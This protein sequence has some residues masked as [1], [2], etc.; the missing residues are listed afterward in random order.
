MPSFLKQIKFA[1][2]NKQALRQLFVNFPDFFP[3]QFENPAET[4]VNTYIALNTFNANERGKSKK[5]LLKQ[6]NLPM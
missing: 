6:K 5:K 1:N 4:L 3:G 2:G